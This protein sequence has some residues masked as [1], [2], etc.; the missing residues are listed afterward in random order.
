LFLFYSSFIHPYTLL[1]TWI[2]TLW[3]NI[4]GA[5]GSR[6]E[7]LGGDGGEDD[8]ATA[9]DGG[10]DDGAGA[11]DVLEYASVSPRQLYGS[12]NA[13]S[14]S[15]AIHSSSSSYRNSS[16]FAFSASTF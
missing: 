5:A 15:D 9:R 2:V 4:A 13:S 14:A 1:I 8:G 12:V 10:E 6:E 16:K 7:A 3:S 11:T